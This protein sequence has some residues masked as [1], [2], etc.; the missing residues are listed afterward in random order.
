M[1]E[2]VWGIVTFFGAWQTVA[3]LSVGVL[4][5]YSWNGAYTRLTQFVLSGVIIAVLVWGLKEYFAID[6][7]AGGAVHGDTK[8]SF[9]SGH[10]AFAT[11]LYGWCM[12]VMFLSRYRLLYRYGI[13]GLLLAIII[14]IAG[15]R[16]TLGAHFVADVVA[17]VG[18]GTLALVLGIGLGQIIWYTRGCNS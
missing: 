5:W 14:A 16:V 13:S 17:G 1:E 3:V 8:Y 15:S 9:P 12:Y 2:L 7:P 4:I 10:A 6:R 11:F 18:V